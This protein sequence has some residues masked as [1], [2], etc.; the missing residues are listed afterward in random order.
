MRARRRG[1]DLSGLTNTCVDIANKV[2]DES[3]F[4]A[5]SGLLSYC[6]ARLMMRPLLVEGMLAT[7]SDAERGDGSAEWVVLVD[8]ERYALS[9]EAVTRESASSPLPARLRYTVAHELT[10]SLAY[11]PRQFGFQLDLPRDGATKADL[12]DMI[13]DETDKL[14]GLLLLPQRAMEAFLETTQNPLTTTKFVDMARRF[15]I[16]RYVLIYRLLAY[17]SQ[18]RRGLLQRSEFRNIGIGIGEWKSDDVA[19]FKRKPLFHNFDRNIMP[20]ILHRISQQNLLPAKS[21]ITDP[22]FIL[23]GGTSNTTEFTGPAGTAKYPDNTQMQI[24]IAVEDRRKRPGKSFIYVVS[25]VSSQDSG[26]NP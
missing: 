16:S 10:H 25:A 4:V 8:S 11:R 12:V 3:G 2:A 18:D 7:I 19:I 21:L 26:I 1:I 9:T 17:Q 13:E 5:I 20:E 22:E 15:G 6:G 14:T 23:C 24:R